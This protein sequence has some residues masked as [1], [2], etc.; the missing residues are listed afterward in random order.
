[1]RGQR[2][3]PAAPYPQER[4]GTH[5]TGGW[6]G[7]RAGLDWC[8]KSR[9][10][11]IWSLDRPACRQSLYRLR[12][13]AHRLWYIIHGIGFGIRLSRGMKFSHVMVYI[14]DAIFK[15]K[16]SGG[17][18]GS[19]YMILAVGRL[20]SREGLQCYPVGVIHH[21]DVSCTCKFMSLCTVVHKGSFVHWT[22]LQK[23]KNLTYDV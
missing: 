19:L 11:G 3:T 7:L 17:L 5:C 23:L 10:T 4:P 22:Q 21:Q 9:P 8:G 12:Y 14:I 20:W 15:V 6:V 2:H 18:F 13:L 1:V 16:E